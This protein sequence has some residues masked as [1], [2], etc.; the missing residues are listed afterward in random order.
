MWPAGKR[1]PPGRA[2]G[3]RRE[4]AGAAAKAARRVAVYVHR[5][6]EP[7]LARLAGERIH[8]AEE[9][10][11]HVVDRDLLAA[12]VARLER[13]MEFD[14]SV[15]ERTLYLALDGQT[16]TGAVALRRLAT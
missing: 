6:P 1:P 7:W 15:A 16:L 2:A 14:L 5:E 11:V 8:R 10:E 4:Q 12:L 13:R 9:L 3:G